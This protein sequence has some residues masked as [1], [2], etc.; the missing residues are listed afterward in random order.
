MLSGFC[1][2]LPRTLNPVPVRLIAEML[3]GNG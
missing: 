2:F 1:D 3:A